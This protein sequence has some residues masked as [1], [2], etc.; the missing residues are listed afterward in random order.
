MKSLGTILLL[1][2]GLCF[3]LA[4]LNVPSPV[5][6]VALGLLLVLAAEHFVS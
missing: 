3:L 5:N 4:T 2:A 6:L 1:I